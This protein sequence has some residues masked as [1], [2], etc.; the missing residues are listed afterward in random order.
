MIRISIPRKITISK[1]NSFSEL[2]FFLSYILIVVTSVLSMTFFGRYLP[3]SMMKIVA[4]LS[5]FMIFA[6]ELQ[7]K[8]NIK[9]LIFV[10][11]ATAAI[12]ITMRNTDGFFHGSLIFTVLLV[13]SGRDVDFRKIAQ[14]SLYVHIFVLG[15]VIISA[16]TGVITNYQVNTEMRRREFLGFLYALY[17][18]TIMLNI[19]ALEIYLQKQKINFLQIALLAAASFWIYAKT[20]ARLAFYSNCLLLVYAVV[21]K[22]FGK[23]MEK[24]RGLYAFMV[25][26]F[27]IC[28]AISVGFSYAY[29]PRIKWISQINSFL[30]NRLQL[31]R[32]SLITYGVSLFGKK[33]S[34]IGNS[35]NAY[36]YASTKEYN[37]VDSMYIQILQRYGII[38]TVVLLLMLT[39][40]CYRC[41]KKK[42]Y[43]LLTI[44]F[45]LAVHAIID[46]LVFH[47]FFNSFWLIIG[48]ELLQERRKNYAVNTETKIKRITAIRR[49]L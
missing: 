49:K 13:Y 3:N 5:I 48:G 30:S 24:M 8:V 39:Y 19:V 23:I 25:P 37:Y 47:P 42:D 35:V 17:P 6:G 22:K 34:W 27:L 15:F 36:G 31:G 38:F 46:D 45:S 9:Q 2:L 43:Y 16:Q 21:M 41:Y 18:A 12:Y 40:I 33:I 29:K 20:D 44:L 14:V 26:S 7:K 28:F 32:N 4:V 10:A 1:N 11:F